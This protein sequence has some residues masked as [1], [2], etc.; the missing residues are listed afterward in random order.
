MK[1]TILFIAAISIAFAV[2]AQLVS[3]SAPK[4]EQGSI[5]FPK[6]IGG[7]AF[8]N[9]HDIEGLIVEGELINEGVLIQELRFTYVSYGEA[10]IK[11]MR[12]RDHRYAP[13]RKGV[14]L[15]AKEYPAYE[16]DTIV[17]VYFKPADKEKIHWVGSYTI[18]KVPNYEKCDIIYWDCDAI[19]KEDFQ[20]HLI[21]SK[22]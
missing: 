2:Q 14:G 15:V 6:I 19:K 3:G 5:T 7:A 1:R 4:S 13:P 8:S 10:C 18:G 22:E 21:E 11:S 17:T 12:I 20:M 9:I 16:T